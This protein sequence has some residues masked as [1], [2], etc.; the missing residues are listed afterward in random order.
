MRPSNY[1][2]SNYEILQNWAEHKAQT[3]NKFK[4]PFDSDH[5]EVEYVHETVQKDSK[6]KN[7]KVYVP[8]DQNEH[9]YW[10]ENLK[11]SKFPTDLLVNG[12]KKAVNVRAIIRCKTHPKDRQFFTLQPY[13]K[14]QR[15]KL[16]KGRP[17][18][19]GWRIY[20][21][22][23]NPVASS[24]G[25]ALG[26]DLNYKVPKATKYSGKVKGV[27]LKGKSGVGA[28]AALTNGNKAWRCP[29]YLEEKTN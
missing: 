10:D 25:S 9:Q 12:N 2:T 6:G 5:F 4:Y 14:N 8:M 29:D 13:C 24:D 7:K 27:G 21:I 17:G 19:C 20:E 15:H 23:P 28:I 16:R 18:E 22:Q 26:F 3:N 11:I 1:D